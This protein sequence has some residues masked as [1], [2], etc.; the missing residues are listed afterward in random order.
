[1]MYPLFIKHFKELS[2]L[3][4]ELYLA[5]GMFDG[6]HLGH[7]T[8]IESAVLSAQ[9][10]GGIS[11][12]LT[13]DPHPSRLFSPAN[14]TRLIMPIKSKQMLLI[15]LGV[16]VVIC[17]QFD[18][19]F[20]SIF[21]EDFLPELKSALPTLKSIY[22]GENFRF[23]KMRAGSVATLIRS[24]DQLGISVFSAERIKRNGQP[25]SST[26]IRKE[27]E[28]GRIE[29]VNDLLGYNYRSEGKVVRGEKLGRKIG[30]P[31]L[32]VPWSPECQPRY[33]VYHVRFRSSTETFFRPGVANYGIRPTVDQ[34]H[35][36]PLLEIHALNDTKVNYGDSI[37]TEWLHFIRPEQ[38]FDSIELLKGQI[39]KDC[40]I[41]RTLSN[42]ND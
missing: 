13:F 9:R 26:R 33:G 34:T 20:S 24:G 17:K 30:F 38:K 8:V 5:I 2:G 35:G 41:A 14:P 22:V 21:A 10:S 15:S 16:D 18:H 39:A 4:K 6:V 31:T 32:N 42:Q 12:V 7:K 25:I 23:G 1:M 11:G 27:L 40:E 3:D 36:D 29:R 28:A 19:A 37:E